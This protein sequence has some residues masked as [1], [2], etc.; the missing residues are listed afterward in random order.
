MGAIVDI[1]LTL[2]PS[3][4]FGKFKLYNV[5]P[6]HLYDGT[7]K[8]ELANENAFEIRLGE[9]RRI[10]ARQFYDMKKWDY[11]ETRAEGLTVTL[12]GK[13]NQED[14]HAKIIGHKD[15]KIGHAMEEMPDQILVNQLF[16]S[17]LRKLPE[18]AVEFIESE[19]GD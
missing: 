18:W 6:A 11:H 15:Q 2:D 17:A 5:T 16:F 7:Q 9:I 8:P 14:G 19:T 13:S 4:Y 1:P 12:M 10:E 3:F